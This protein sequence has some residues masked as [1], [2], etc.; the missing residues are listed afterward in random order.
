L[1]EDQQTYLPDTSYSEKELLQKIAEGDEKAFSILFNTYSTRLYHF[2]IKHNGNAQLSDDLVQDVFTKL[3]LTRETLVAIENIQH[4]LFSMARNYAIDFL[5]QK[6]REKKRDTEWQQSLEEI[7][8]STNKEFYLDIIDR[9]IV[10]LPDQQ[11]KTWIMSRRE[12][13][14]YIE[15]AENLNVSRETVKTNLQ[16]ANA[17]IRKYVL[18][19]LK[20]SSLLGLLTFF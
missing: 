4:Y 14:T 12:K 18:K 20:V 19:C 2:A 5:R 15:I 6:L 11:R 1:T 8:E 17:G 7:S 10:Q 16:Y 3:W 9:A 13:K